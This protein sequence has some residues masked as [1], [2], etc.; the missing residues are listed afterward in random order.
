MKFHKLI[1]VTLFFFLNSCS[2][3]NQYNYNNLTVNS[4]YDTHFIS[5]DA[6]DLLMNQVVSIHFNKGFNDDEIIILVDGKY[7]DH[8]LIT[9]D[10]ITSH[11]KTFVINR[12][13]L[14]KSIAVKINSY[15]LIYIDKFSIYNHVYIDIDKSK[16]NTTLFYT[17]VRPINL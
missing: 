13:H 17:N 5:P 14:V 8:N 6:L 11:A 9:T 2:Y 15:N 16:K 1:Y 3:I 10:E 12:E 7:Y 4:V